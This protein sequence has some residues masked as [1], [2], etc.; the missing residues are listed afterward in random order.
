M[1]WYLVFKGK[2]HNNECLI[3]I[4]TDEV[5]NSTPNIFTNSQYHFWYKDLR[6]H[7]VPVLINNTHDNFHFK[8]QVKVNITRSVIFD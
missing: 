7:F 2:L 4:F 6:D 5:L 3:Y 1:G 8:N